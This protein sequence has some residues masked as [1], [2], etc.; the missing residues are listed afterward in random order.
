M[1]K[2]IATIFAVAICL[3]AGGARAD[4]LST[5]DFAHAMKLMVDGYTGTETLAN[6]PVLVRISE[7][8]L[9]GF[10]YSDLS[11]SRGKDIAFF[12][13]AGNHIP[14]EIQT[15]SW[16]STD[17][18]SQ[19]WVLLPQMTQGTTFFM[20]Y[21][22][23]ASGVFV[24][25]QNPW[26]EYVGVWHLDET[27]G[28]NKPIYDSTAN[29]LNGLTVNTGSPSVY[30]AG[31]IGNARRITSDTNNNPGFDSGITIDLSDSAKKATVDGLATEFTA[32]FWY[33]PYNATANYEYL[34]S[35][36][37]IDGDAGWGLQFGGQS[38]GR[39]WD[40][41]RIY[42]GLTGANSNFAI[43][44]GA[45]SAALG[46]D[47]YGLYIPEGAR[48]KWQKMDCVWSG[49]TYRIYVDGEL[50]AIGAL[51]GNKAANHNATQNLSIGGALMPD[52]N[53]GAKI[54]GGRGFNGYMDEVRLIRGTRS[55]DWI[56]ADFETVTNLNFVTI[57]PAEDLTVR[58]AVSS[59]MSGVTNVTWNSAVVGCSFI[60]FGAG[61]TGTI[62][63]KFWA[64]GAA[65]P[66]EWTALSGAIS[67]IGD[68]SVSSP[69]LVENT[70]YNY[71]L[72]V[73]DGDGNVKSHVSG[74]FTTPV[75]LAVSWAELFGTVG[76]TNVSVMSVEVGGAIQSLGSSA[77]CAVEG[78]FW[79][80]GESEP[81]V[82]TTIVAGIAQTGDFSG[83]VSNLEEGASYHY[84]L[85]AIGA[86]GAATEPIAGTFMTAPGLTVLWSESTGIV[87]VGYNFVKIGG[88]VT[89]LGNASSCSIQRKIW[90]SGESEPNWTTLKTG[91]GKNVGFTVAVSNLTA[92]TTYNYRL[93]AVGDDDDEETA[94]LTGTVTTLGDAGEVIGSEHTHFFDDGTNAFWVVND[95]ERYLE[96]TV[97]GY[98][99]TETLT[100]F[101]VM[102]EVRKKDTNGF[103]YDDFYHYEGTDL[104]FVDEKGHIIPHE[105]DTWNRSGQSLIW[106]RLPEMNNGTKFTMCYRS[107][108]LD[109]L[110]DAG[111]VFE[112]YVG[113]WHMN[114]T[115]D[116]VVTIADSAPY[117]LPGEAHANSLAS[118]NGRVG[119]CRRVA[120]QPGTSST[121]GRI[122]V[123]DH[124][125]ILRTGVGNV[126]TFSGF[127]KLQE[128]PPKWSYLVSRKSN[129][130]DRGWGIQ[131]AETITDGGRVPVL[132]VWSGSSEKNKFQKFNANGAKA[133]DWNYWTF[134]Y[135]NRGPFGAGTNGFFHAYLNGQEL[136]STA[137]GFPLSFDVANDATATY[138]GLVIGGQQIGTG[139]FNG[140]VDEARY[141]KG[142]RS[143]DWIRAEYDSSMQQVYW[144]DAN[145]RF[146]TKGTVSKGAESL[147]PVVIWERGAN[148]PET[149]IDVSYAYVQFA[150]IVTY[151]GVGAD[152]CRIEYQLWVDGEEVPTEW[153]TLIDHVTAG[154][155]FSI[156]VT[157]LKQDMPY[158]F[159]IRAVNVI[160]DVFEQRYREQQN[161]ERVGSFRTTGNVNMSEYEGEFFRLDNKFVHRFRAGS[162][163]FTTPDYATNVEIM[164][165]AG[166]GGGGYKVGG[167]GGG[168]GLFYSAS[169]PVQTNTAY[170]I[171]VGEGGAGAT[172]LTMRGENGELSYFALAS[173]EANPLIRMHG[174][175]GGGSFV[176]NANYAKGADGA[177]GGGGSYAF[178]G[179]STLNLGLPEEL[180]PFGHSGGQGNDK[181]TGGADQKSAAGGGGG[182]GRAGL[183]ASFDSWWGGGTGGVGVECRITG[184]DLFYG[185]GGGG[186]YKYKVAGDSFTKP[187]AGGSGIG[188]N[189]ADVRNGIPATSGVDNTGAGGG[190][191]SM[192]LG[193]EHDKTYWNGGHGG[194]GVVLISYEAHGR[195][196]ISDDPRI[197]MTSCYYTDEQHYA[198]IGYRAYWAGV[199]MELNDLYV[200]YSIS[201]SNDVANGEGTWVKVES[202]KIGIGNT[203]F[204][205]PEVG[206]TYWVRLVARKEA[207]SFMYSDEIASFDVPAIRNNG[208]TWHPHKPDND[209]DIDTTLDY[210]TIYYNLYYMDAD[211]HLYFY[212]S[213][214]EADLQG[215][216]A[217]SGSG[218]HFLDLG[219]GRQT[220]PGTQ[221]TFTVPSSEGLERN[222][223]YYTRLATGN[224]AGTKFF[225]SKAIMVLE[226][227]EKPRVIFPAATWSNNVAK[228]TFLETT[229]NLDPATVDLIAYYGTKEEVQ[230][231]TIL[232]SAMSVNLGN[233]AEYPDDVEL[234]TQFPLWSLADTN[235][236]VRLALAT[237][238]VNICL[239]QRN[240]FLQ[241]I[242][243]VPANT[244][245]V[246]ANAIP[247]TGC[248][249]DEPQTLDYYVTYGGYT[250]GVGW[251]YYERNYKERVED[252][253]LHCDVTSTSDVGEYDILPG[254]LGNVYMPPYHD[255]S[256]ESD[257]NGVYYYYERIYCGTEYS[258]TNAHFTL[259]IDDIS[260]P[261]TGDPCDTSDLVCTTNGLRLSQP[262]S[263]Q[264]RVSTNEWSSTMP[265]GYTD[266]GTHTVQFKATAPNHDDVVGT[267]KITVTPAP[268]SVTMDDVTT[269]YTGSVIT[270]AVVTNVT[271]LL[272]PERNP[273]TCQFR[274]EAGEWMDEV[275]SFTLP[276]TYKLF[277][278]ASAPNHADAVT[279]CTLVING[280]DFMVNMDGET[281][282]ATPIV[283]AR[284][285]WLID[286]SGNTSSRTSMDGVQLSVAAH[287]Y[288]KLNEVCD[289]GLTLWQNYVLERKDFGKRVVATILQ[290]EK[291]LLENTVV[292]HFPNIEPLMSAGL[293]VQYR[294]DRKLRGEQEFTLGELTSK[295]ETSIALDQGDP[296]GL[297]VFNMVLSSTNG[298]YTGQSVISS[299]TTVGVM[300][301]SSALTN[302]VTVAPWL[303][304][305]VDS[306]NEIDV[307]V[308]DVV[309]PNGL[310]SGD[311]IVAYDSS[312]KE[313]CGWTHE[314]GTS[315]K[316]LTTVT[317][318]GISIS[319]AETTQMSPGY[320]FWLVRSAPTPYFYLVGR[321]TGGGFAAEISGGTA[322][323]PV[324]TLVANPTMCDVAINDI[325]WQ[326]MPIE[327]DTIVIPNEG[328][329]PYSLLWRNGAWSYTLRERDPVTGKVKTKR[330]TD[331]V[332][333]AG[334]GFWYTR[335]GEGFSITWPTSWP[336]TTE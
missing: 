13:E 259:E 245:L 37:S 307:A 278:R 227:I 171:H 194:D 132:R 170:R 223:I 123:F 141:S 318:D 90:E 240:Q 186:G 1:T 303:S 274:D 109:P 58:W 146:V 190:G 86:N 250:N 285:Q 323:A 321:Y 270:P 210:A 271:G 302:T 322:S 317:K 283:M 200:L 251:T 252:A 122:L 130:Q 88:T 196:P 75:G 177:S 111:N 233:C 272:H 84:K 25:N 42:G 301:V 253:T 336:E 203:T 98:K 64:D 91:L 159:R 93:R 182:A 279:N 153:T 7:S 119:N 207:N 45:T 22:T 101:P 16:K 247:K 275:P 310:S 254:E 208:A 113:V 14:S 267:F 53:P 135:D 52:G 228:V 173:D 206:Y 29:E 244:L 232:P 21:N 209:V 332:V 2:R 9:P 165:V 128:E 281:G 32:S 100:N 76:V 96:F 295:Y 85:R 65:E 248:Y 314:S 24:T 124:D 133:T 62:K 179:G 335:R 311:M 169:Y 292:V 168:G 70:A 309:N 97:T 300:R 110:P 104:A 60:G 46:G 148:L 59:G 66:S 243:A 163:N 189:A 56:K 204:T 328:A 167:G 273:L 107:P 103:S 249:G 320:A 18:E 181:L 290:S 139:A 6:F 187:G 255:T 220:G 115:Q 129:D 49:S 269:N 211:A 137:G 239:S 114:E 288:A 184:E 330:V 149:I 215:D 276:G 201:S 176:D 192:V 47:G 44:S 164:V 11:N 20:C 162:Y 282:Y 296:T 54:K 5:N 38:A 263:Y 213:E 297:Y 216:T 180:R 331:I 23:S 118:G 28:K 10:L 246:Y 313:Y 242:T 63:G 80:D 265:S 224:E 198:D 3:A 219:T 319:E 234:I 305:S 151:C 268:L 12:D 199:Q 217:P 82:W 41:I 121:Y 94:P 280:W 15:N 40:Q 34:I 327:G 155:S 106:V 225:L 277:F 191:G 308:S 289:N 8:G 258:V 72:C 138:D 51:K 43:G 27:G 57:A 48:E 286:N 67:Q 61:Q 222:K 95:F 157:G 136:S 99:G 120:Q 145:K 131:Y 69:V 50:I 236:Y 125:D 134:V 160:W 78:K 178:V 214:N 205:P 262:I 298:L 142:M 17:N 147:V 35:R 83:E 89:A 31:R 256:D 156:P 116:G 287:R 102:V 150:G 306:T 117:D 334:T 19:A 294:L 226:T 299:V 188:G 229:A 230:G 105:I 304:M 291:T 293:K 183:S 174:G 81:A 127:Y 316:A 144:N 161:R 325:D 87:E 68:I 221:D 158:N 112:K 175:G 260:V 241:L 284:P 172:N 185:A 152:E 154:Q 30:N 333:P 71:E 324:S 315:W 261:Y 79:V 26:A 55:A 312:E 77:T 140:F 33:Q 108:L 202:S 36:K 235:Y 257:P 143:A 197:T 73:V 4:Y 92:G 237:N 126:F 218:V 329:A 264:Y 212:W 195:D 326:G 266:V 238:G 74:T 193:D 166:G 39:R 231:K